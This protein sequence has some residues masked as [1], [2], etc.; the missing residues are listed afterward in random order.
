MIK[1][2]MY[3]LCAVTCLLVVTLS[4]CQGLIGEK[5]E[6]IST[7]TDSR[8]VED[9]GS[10]P[11]TAVMASDSTLA[12]HT[13]FRPEDLSAFGKKNKLPVIAWGNG[14]CS[15]SPSGHLNFLSE[16]AS[17]GFLVIAIG[18]M[19]AEGQRGGGMRGGMRGGGMP[20]GMMGGGMRRG[21][22]P[23]GDTEGESTN[24]GMGGGMMGGGTTSSQLIDAI[25]WA[26]AQDSNNTSIYYNKID[27]ESIAVAGMSCGGLQAYDV[28]PDPRISTVMI[29]NSGIFNPGTAPGGGRGGARGGARGGGGM[30]LPPLSKEDLNKLHS[31]VIYILGDESDMAYANGSDDFE[32]I[33]NLPV[34]LASMAVGHGGT[35]MQPH[36]GEFAKVATAWCK[37]QL[38]GDKEAAKMFTGEPC[39][40]TKNET[41]IEIK[42]K[43]IP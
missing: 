35:Y 34:F 39:G 4:G 13:I 9:G 43:N 19:P 33:D 32:R 7:E 12:T 5:V 11:Y 3:F 18:P 10:G 38:K 8:T 23:G 36:G 15:N 16:V 40:L 21:P 6:S 27:T 22:A 1:L 41:W 26:I 25:D 31:P 17:H 24:Y 20:G 42:K 28:A 30:N 29:C 37:W 14:A 2:R